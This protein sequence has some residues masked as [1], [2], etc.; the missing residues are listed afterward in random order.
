MNSAKILIVDDE[1][2][3]RRMLNDYFSKRV[4][5]EII[6]A[7]NGYEALEKFKNSNID[8]ILLDIKM[9]GISGIEVMGKVRETAKDLPMI[10]LSKLESEE[11]ENKIK[12]FGADFVNKPFSLKVVFEKSSERLK[13]RNK[14]FPKQI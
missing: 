14:F 13:S 12:S 1:S 8:L 6:E 4:E 5:C 2:H 3:T 10:V 11:M 9:P 7:E